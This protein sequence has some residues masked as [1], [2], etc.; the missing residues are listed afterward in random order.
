MAETSLKDG[1]QAADVAQYLHQHPQLLKEFPDLAM[2]LSMP[3]EHGQAASLASYQLD[4]LRDKNRELQRRQ[5]ELIEIASDNERLMMQV[6]ELT[7]ALLR[8]P[9][10]EQ[11]VRR[12]VAG[13]TENFHTD[14]VR[15]LLF[16]DGTVLPQADWLLLLPDGAAGMPDFAEFLARE[17]P[18]FGR[19]STQKLQHLFGEQASDVQSVALMRL[20]GLG[21][22]AIGSTDANHFHPGMGTVFIKMIAEAVTAAVTRF[23]V[24]D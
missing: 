14:L 11:V 10:L 19:L 2:Q 1:L 12:I 20:A 18:L 13:L 15:L 6:H 5:D 22:L 3:R 17:E 8:A 9:T 24:A 7:L 16:R 4:V 21:M 23:P